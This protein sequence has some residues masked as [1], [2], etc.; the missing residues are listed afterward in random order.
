M[1][2]A[3]WSLADWGRKLSCN[4]ANF[5]NLMILSW[6]N[7]KGNSITDMTSAS[8]TSILKSVKDGKRDKCCSARIK[9]VRVQLELDYLDLVTRAGPEASNT[10]LL[11]EYYIQLPQ[12]TKDLTS[13]K[14]IQYHLTIYLGGDDFGTL[15]PA[16]I[17]WTLLN[18]THQDSPYNLLAPSFNLTSCQTNNTPSMAN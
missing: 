4:W 9:F 14:N 8:D 13:N 7:A 18:I 12:N 3:K 16:D 5:A 17:K 1:L 15:P 10:V 6:H 2:L 11:G